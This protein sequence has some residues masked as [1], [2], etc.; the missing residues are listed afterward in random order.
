MWCFKPD[1]RLTLSEIRS[2]F[3][4]FLVMIVV[5]ISC[6]HELALAVFLACRPRRIPCRLFAEFR[7]CSC[8]LLRRTWPSFG[9]SIQGAFDISVSS[10]MLN[11]LWEKVNEP[12]SKIFAH[13]VA[14]IL[15][16]SNTLVMGECSVIL[17]LCLVMVTRTGANGW[18]LDQSVHWIICLLVVLAFIFQLQHC[19]IDR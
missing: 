8:R 7:Y 17:N 5:D 19:H 1:L 9:R 12:E 4:S 10:G 2:F 15:R 16:L 18:K 11:V 13:A 3:I 6:L 14:D